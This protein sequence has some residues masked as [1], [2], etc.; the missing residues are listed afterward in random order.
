V[1][2][3]PFA[4]RVEQS[5]VSQL[6]EATLTGAKFSAIEA[7]C[8]VDCDIKDL[9][10]LS[11]QGIRPTL[12]VQHKHTGFTPLSALGDGIRRVLAM[13]TS[14]ASVRGGLLL[15]DEIET[16]IHK[17]ALT[18]VFEWLVQACKHFDVQLFAT[19]HSLEAIDAILAAELCD[20]E[21]LVAFRLPE[22]HGHK[23]V[24]RF[25]SDIL[26]NLRFERGLDIR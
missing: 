16:A 14:I 3:S 6:S 23:A 8:L 15:I 24:K 17:D 4:H 9:E 22:V 26:D 11:R 19:T 1:T 13:A 18:R 7:A 20:P 10:I 5:Q 2:V 25:S 21:S 12:F